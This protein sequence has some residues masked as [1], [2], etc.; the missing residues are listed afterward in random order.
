MQPAFEGRVK[1]TEQMKQNTLPEQ[2]KAKIQTKVSLSSE[3]NEG[4]HFR[5]ITREG[6]IRTC[7]L[8]TIITFASGSLGWL[9]GLDMLGTGL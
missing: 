9:L 8:R 5:D 1:Q 7:L 4:E 6:P 3:I 2:E